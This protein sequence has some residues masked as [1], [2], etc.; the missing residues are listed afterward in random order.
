MTIKNEPLARTERPGTGGGSARDFVLAGAGAGIVAGL[1]SWVFAR[2][3]LH[4]LI[5]R[6][7]AQEGAG[8]DHGTDH[9]G[10][11][12]A[13]LG[14]SDH[15]GEAAEIFSRSTQSNIGSLVA[16]VAF[17]VAIGIM[18]AIAVWTVLALWRGTGVAGEGALGPGTVAPGVVGAVGAAVAFIAVTLIP[19]AKYPANP[20]AVGDANTIGDRSASFITMTVASIIVAGLALW[21]AQQLRTHV[22]ALATPAIIAAVGAGYLGVIWVVAELLPDFDEVPA[23]FP[24]DTLSDFRFYSLVNH[25]IEWLVLGLVLAFAWRKKPRN[26]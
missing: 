10:T 14:G 9:A 20:P 1:I 5:D 3:F 6:A 25:G 2:I 15:V 16:I 12:H 26:A 17:T 21:A 24:A 22:P 23:D 4:P 11:D 19:F 7:I 18:L 8:H 13:E